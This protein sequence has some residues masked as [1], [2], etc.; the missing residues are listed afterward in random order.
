MDEIRLVTEQFVREALPPILVNDSKFERGR[1]LLIAGSYGMAGSAI[2]S[3]RAALLSGVGYL[4]LALPS[5]IYGMVTAAVPEAVCTIYDPE[6]PKQ[7]AEQ[8]EELLDRAD[9]VAAGPGLGKLRSSVITVLLDYFSPENGR[10][11][12]ANGTERKD[13]KL[14]LDA[15]A[16][17]ALTTQGVPA[18]L[19]P[20]LLAADLLLTPHAGE[21]A[22]L[23]G[24]KHRIT[25]KEREAL[26]IRASETYEAAVLFKG[27]GTLIR[28]APGRAAKRGGKA[29]KEADTVRL[30]KNPTGGPGLA[31]AGSGDVLTGIAGAL[32]AEGMDAFTAGCC[33]AYLHGLAGDLAAEKFGVRSMLPSDVIQMIPEAL[34]TVDGDVVAVF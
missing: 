30:Y 29:K 18:S 12:D 4:T 9:A 26:I 34:L 20:A 16:L 2:L 7:M 28:E 17:N 11:K 22:R 21:M 8:F 19:M 15:D 32:M 10:R 23:L 25:E 3:A 24:L 6:D 5:S 33:G 14:L 13:K 27:N 31:R 1:L